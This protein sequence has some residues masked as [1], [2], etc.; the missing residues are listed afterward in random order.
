[1]IKY[2]LASALLA[3]GPVLAGPAENAET[4]AKFF[5]SLNGGDMAVWIGTMATDVVTHEPVGTPPNKGHDGVMAWAAN[6]AAMGFKSVE[7]EV[8][9]IFPSPDENAVVWTTTFVLPNDEVVKI[10]GVDIH[11]FDSDGLIREVRAYF[12]PSPLMAAMGQ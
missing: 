4:S 12:D 6:N 8:Q 2:I 10:P 7:V 1:M 5:D 3:A 11:R 9:G